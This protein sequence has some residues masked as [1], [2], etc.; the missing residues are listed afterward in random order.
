MECI[1]RGLDPL[2]TNLVV[3]DASRSNKTIC[4]AVS[5]SLKAY[6]ISGRAR[7]FEVIQAVKKENARRLSLLKNKSFS[8]SSYDDLQLKKN[9]ELSL[10]YIAAPP[11]MAYY[12]EYSTRIYDIYLKYVAAEDIHVYS[13]DEVFMDVSNYLSSSN[14][15][16]YDLAKKILRDVLATTGISATAGIGSNL[17]LAK[18]AMDIQAKRTPADEDGFHIAYLDEI[19]YRQLLWDHKPITD[20]WRVGKGYANKLA[21][22]SLH[23]MGDIALCSLGEPNQYHNE[24]LLFKLF[25]INAELL[26]DHAWGY[27]PCTIADIKKYKPQSTS[28]GSRQVLQTPYTYE[29]GLLV[30]KEMAD[31][32]ALDLVSKDLCT[33]QI[34]ITVGYDIEN[35]ADPKIKQKYLGN[36]TTDAYGRD[37]PK[38][39]HGTANLDD[40][41]SSSKLIVEAASQLYERIM[42]KQL[43]IRRFNITANKVLDIEEAAKENKY[44]QLDMFSLT[45]EAKQEEEQMQEDLEK[46][47]S[48]QEAMLSLKQKYGKNTILKGMS[49]Q[50]DATAKDRN[51]RIGGHKA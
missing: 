2:T 14:L 23:S 35:L 15:T 22:H 31:Q 18:I 29:Q 11:R 10:D 33:Q 8:A 4:L 19:S 6:G 25:G 13:I 17:Y 45:S 1:E 5:P 46:E 42:D 30:I 16:E 34:T 9:P 7:L 43:L 50:E 26:I 44:K 3:A 21:K 32:L 37:V 40:A 24:D 36:I 12:I 28:I 38:A 47:K 27:E 39:A 41:T 51:K 48:L 20:F 49:L